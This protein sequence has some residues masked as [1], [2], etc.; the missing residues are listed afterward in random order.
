LSE[1]LNDALESGFQLEK[2]EE[3]RLDNSGAT[4]RQRQ[5]FLFPMI[6]LFVFRKRE[7]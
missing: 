7:K 1:T 3:I 5:L 6:L 2:M 4:G